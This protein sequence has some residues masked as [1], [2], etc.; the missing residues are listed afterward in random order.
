MSF[1]SL[2]FLVL[3]TAVAALY[4]RLAHREQNGLLLVASL[5]FYGWWDWRFLGLL[6]L[7]VSVDYACGLLVDRTRSPR[8]TPAAPRALLATAVSISLGILGL[9]KYY[10]FFATSLARLAATLDVDL[11]LSTL[12]FV[13][14]IG[15]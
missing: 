5:V 10:E 3:F 12:R 4:P 9:F 2:E 6:L 7:S 11:P 14:P 13:L 15:I 8:R 1:V